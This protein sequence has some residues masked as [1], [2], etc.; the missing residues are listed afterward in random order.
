MKGRDR[1]DALWG[2]FW[3]EVGKFDR[4]FVQIRVLRAEKGSK[5]EKTLEFPHDWSAIGVGG[6]GPY[7]V[8]CTCSNVCAARGVPRGGALQGGER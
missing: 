3:F 7:S 8:V 5:S 2:I 1:W 4:L 6:C